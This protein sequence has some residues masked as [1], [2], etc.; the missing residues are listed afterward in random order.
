[1]FRTQTLAGL[2][3][4]GRVLVPGRSRATG[5]LRPPAIHRLAWFCPLP[6][7]QRLGAA[8]RNNANFWR[9][10]KGRG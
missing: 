9:R 5:P 10:G 1:M 2:T 7:P 6:L 3:A 4:G 8:K